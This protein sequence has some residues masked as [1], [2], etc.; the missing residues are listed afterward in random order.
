MNTKSNHSRLSKLKHERGFTL[1]EALVTLSIVSILASI[2]I[3]NSKELTD[4]LHKGDARQQLEF[5][6][7]RARNDTMNEGCR[8]IMTVASDSKSYTF[9]FD[10][11]PYSSPAVIEKIIFIRKLPRDVTIT[12]SATAIIDARGQSIDVNGNLTSVTVT[13]TPRGKTGTVGTIYPIGFVDF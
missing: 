7:R 11:P 5:D 6:L 10:Y 12:T 1:L 8:G 9:G 13:I 2:G 4:S 3:L